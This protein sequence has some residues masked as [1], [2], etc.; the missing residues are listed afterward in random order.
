MK[1]QKPKKPT[2]STQSAAARADSRLEL[3]GAAKKIFAE[4]G[5]DG[6]SVKDIA[7]EAGLNV[8]L[9]SYYFGGKDGLYR[10]CLEEFGRGR[11][12]TAQRILV[13][14][15]ESI[16]DFRVRLRVFLEEFMEYHLAEPEIT[17]ILHRDCSDNREVTKDLFKNVFLKLFGHLVNFFKIAQKKGFFR[18][19]VNTLIAAGQLFGGMIHT[20]R[21][22]S[23]IKEHMQISLSQKKHRDVFVNEI[24]KNLLEGVMKK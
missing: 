7:D 9:V 6:A 1:K 4:K 12:E 11:L 20:I 14:D 2:K 24:L 8:S 19:D 3:M 10:A 16:D 5:L 18:E 21:M 22:E 23:V 15:I 17:R 13:S